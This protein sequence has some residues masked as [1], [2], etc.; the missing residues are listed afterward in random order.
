MKIGLTGATGFLGRHFTAHA[1]QAGH[2]VIGYSRQTG[3]GHR[4]L[5][6]MDFSG[7]DAVVHL[8][9]ENVLGLWTRA[10][11]QRIHA[12][13]VMLTQRIVT[14]MRSLP[15]PPPIL[16][17]ASGVSY[18]GDRGDELLDETSTLGTGFLGEV[19]RDWEGAVAQ[20]GDFARTVSVRFGMILGPDGGA[21]PLLRRIFKLGLGGRL[22]SGRQWMAWIHVDDAARQLLAAVETASVRGPVNGVAPQTVT[23]REFTRCLAQAL[24]RPAWFPV[25]TVVLKMLPG[26]SSRMFLDSTRVMPR[27]WQAEEFAFQYASLETAVQALL[28]RDS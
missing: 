20:A 23:N 1:T 9:G 4:A 21:W 27:V 10:K 18:Y 14:A 25:P 28:T 3:N 7:L 8:A 15:K 6:A 2:E 22:G 16:V 17:S 24:H 11:K 12:S 5:E 26:G 13:R 19:V